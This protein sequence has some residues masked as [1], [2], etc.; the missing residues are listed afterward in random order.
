[1]IVIIVLLGLHQDLPG[2]RF[3]TAKN[4][5]HGMCRI[6]FNKLIFLPVN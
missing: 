4:D 2:G 1:M 3:A 6:G 5:A